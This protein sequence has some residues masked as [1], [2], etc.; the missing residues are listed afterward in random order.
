MVGRIDWLRSRDPAVWL[1]GLVTLAGAVL[2]FWQLGRQS[3]WYD[4]VVTAGLMR[5]SFGTMLHGVHTGE[6]SPFL[7]YVLAWC[8]SKVVG[9]SEVGL[10]S[11]SALVGTAA[12][13]VTYCAG[14]ALVA[15]R[16]GVLAAALVAFSPFL[17][18]YSQ[19][20]RVYSLFVLVG[21]LSLW[22]FAEAWASPTRRTLIYW[23]VASALA[24]W[25]HYFAFFLVGAEGF[26]L[27]VR[28]ATR[29][30]ALGPILG[31]IA[32]AAAIA[33]LLRHQEYNGL[34]TFIAAIPL[35]TRAYSAAKWFVAG[36]GSF[37]H[38]WWIAGGLLLIGA[39]SL[40]GLADRSERR[41]ALVAA[42]LGAAVIIGP[43][44][45]V[46]HG[47]DFWY[48]RNLIV[49]W[50]AL[51]VAL[52]AG[53]TGRSRRR[54]IAVATLF[55]ASLV[56]ASGAL[57]IRLVGGADSRDNWRG[58]ARCLAAPQPRRVFVVYPGFEGTALRYYRPSLRELTAGSEPVDEIDVVDER[59]PGFK[60][61]AGFRAVADAC[62]AALT[63]TA[64]RSERPRRLGPGRLRPPTIHGEHAVVFVDQ[65]QESN[66]RT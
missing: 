38:M 64:Y 17:I 28:P 34:N 12:I 45:A 5:S 60:V 36:A 21:S 16:A 7:Y 26:L 46:L 37:S 65:P 25:T 27:L 19:E 42:L 44:A 35:R 9:T 13:P 23:A 3:F 4:E 47:K 51:A 55:A 41:G 57:A 1:V 2:R 58:L 31:V 61:P 24:L 62:S 33:P 52:S 20:A 8:W 18:W 63:V 32:A 30:P 43:L 54:P 11:F 14:R 29:R 48:Y 59:P 22:A 39:I 53:L 6:S 66:G 15:R 10:R 50:P 40:L 56:I 49:A